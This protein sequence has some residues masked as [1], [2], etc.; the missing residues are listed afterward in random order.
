VAAPRL[1]FTNGSRSTSASF[2]VHPDLV[3]LETD[4]ETLMDVE[5]KGSGYRDAF[6]GITQG[7]LYLVAFT[8]RISLAADGASIGERL[9]AFAV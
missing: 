3:A 4:G 8:A 1:S 9:A 6:V 5:A 2:V 7:E